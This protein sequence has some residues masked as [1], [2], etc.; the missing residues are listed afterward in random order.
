VN[1][2]E[3]PVL[4]VVLAVLWLFVRGVEPAVD[5]V[6]GQFL[7]GLAVGFPVAYVFRRLYEERLDL[8]ATLRAV[9]YAVLYAVVFTREI[10]VAN[11]DVA[12]RVLAP[13]DHI[14]PEVIL[15][16][17]RVETPLAI[18]TIANSITLT[19]GTITLD[20]VE[21]ANGLYVHVIDGENLATFVDPIRTWEEYALRVF[22]EDLDPDAPEPE[23]TISGGDRYDR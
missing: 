21:E 9:P 4:G 6:A 11:L 23:I 17:L 5:A 16:P 12:Y 14:E 7:L 2:R 20:Y 22:D 13:G 3:W 19:P 10:A 18:T 8:G 1:V 15:V